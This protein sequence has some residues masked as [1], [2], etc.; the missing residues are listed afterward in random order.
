MDVRMQMVVKLVD[1][2]LDKPLV[3]SKLAEHV[4]LSPSHFGYLFRKELGVSFA[5][6]VKTLRMQKAKWLL[7]NSLLSVKEVM[8]HVG[9]NDSSH[10]VRDFEHTFGC[11]PV[12]H[13]RF[14]FSVA[15]LDVMKSAN[16]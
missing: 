10:F 8:Y 6:Y 5:R 14:N 12:Q 1:N 9:I 7:E 13:R 15:H 16:K 11:S 4:N 2:N 3:A